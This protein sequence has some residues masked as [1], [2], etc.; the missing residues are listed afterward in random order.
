MTERDAYHELSAYT[1]AHG[2]P[3]FIHQH[4]VDAFA[5]QMANEQ[6]KPIK[7]TFA[8]VGLYLHVVRQLT[9]KEV[10]QAHQY[11]ARHKRPWPAFVLPRDRGSITACDVLARAEGAERDQAIHAWS[12]SVWRTFR[13]SEHLVTDLLTNSGGVFTHRSPV[14]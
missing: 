1:L 8:L 14:A 6:T 13:E 10:Q 4:V 7:L 5:A 12:A 9:G 2:D 3:A 11:L